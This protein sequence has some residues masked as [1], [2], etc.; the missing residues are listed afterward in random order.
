MSSHL[1]PLRRDHS[2]MNM[3]DS[4]PEAE[5]EGGFAKAHMSFGEKSERSRMSTV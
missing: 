5:K 2:Y 4:S 1:M 3:Y